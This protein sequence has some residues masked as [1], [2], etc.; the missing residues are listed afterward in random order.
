MNYWAK[1]TGIIVSGLPHT[2]Q[3]EIILRN[4]KAK[5]QIRL[6]KEGFYV[7]LEGIKIDPFQ[8]ELYTRGVVDWV[9][10]SFGMGFGEAAQEYTKTTLIEVISQFFYLVT[11][12]CDISKSLN[13]HLFVVVLIFFNLCL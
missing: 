11:Y 7:F 12:F 8:F 1:I 2:G 10:T 4:F 13:G 3:A 9:K 6:K 5:I